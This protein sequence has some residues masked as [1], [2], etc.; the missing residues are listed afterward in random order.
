[1]ISI[2]IPTY[3][4][5]KPIS[6]CLKALLSQTIDI[7]EYE[8]I[9]V[10]DGSLDNTAEVVKNF[11]TVQLIRQENQGPAAARNKGAKHAKGDIIIFTDSD[12]VPFNNWIEEMIRP[13][14]KNSEVAGT[15]GAYRTQQRELA[16]RFVQTEYED[17]YDLLGKTAYIDFIDTYAAAFKREVFMQFGGYDTSFPVACAEDVELTFRMSSEGYKMVFNPDAIV[18]HTHPQSF[19]DY[20]KKKYK[21]AF[22]RILAVK[23]NPTKFIKDSHTP[24]IMK[25]QVLF[26]P[27]LAVSLSLTML[28]DGMLWL[29][30]GILALFFISTIPFSLKAFKKDRVIGGSSWICGK[31]GL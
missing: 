11:K 21:F 8:V 27:S 23:K 31:L 25:F 9:V 30:L 22:W 14:E 17:K 10:D 5:E 6:A 16:S 2:I 1:M 24:Q 4:A 28:F 3:N 29:I 19:N 12:C 7:S 20:F 26:F 18:Y 13:F 15:K